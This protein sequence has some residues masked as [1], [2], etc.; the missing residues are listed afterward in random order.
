MTS[1]P[2]PKVRIEWALH[3]CIKVNPKQVMRGSGYDCIEDRRHLEHSED[4]RASGQVKCWGDTSV[5]PPPVGSLYGGVRSALLPHESAG[6]GLYCSDRREEKRASKFSS[7]SRC[8]AQSAG[9]RAACRQRFTHVEIEPFDRGQR[10]RHAFAIV[11]DSCD[12][13]F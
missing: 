2:A 5:L 10:R 6:P 1:S 11:V 9:E 4:V 12:E 13:L 8:N 3:E 7:L